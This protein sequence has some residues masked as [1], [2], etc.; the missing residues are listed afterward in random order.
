MIVRI[1]RGWL[2]YFVLRENGV[3]CSRILV[4]EGDCNFV[5]RVWTRP[6]MRRKGYAA[7]IVEHAIQEIGFLSVYSVTKDGEHFWPTTKARLLYLSHY[8]R[9]DMRLTK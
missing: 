7:R 2:T 4:D 1:V 6:D 9:M 3:V 5:L 8:R